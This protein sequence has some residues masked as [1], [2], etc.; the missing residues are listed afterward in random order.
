MMF[1]NEKEASI[2]PRLQVQ[3]KNKDFIMRDSIT[4]KQ[5]ETLWSEL[6]KLKTIGDWKLMVSKFRDSYQLTD[7]EAIQIANKSF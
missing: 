4:L 3:I 6:D 5:M 7:F 1:E 2:D